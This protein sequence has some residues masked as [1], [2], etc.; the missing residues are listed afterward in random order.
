LYL[1]WF[2]FPL[3]WSLTRLGTFNPTYH[4]LNL[5]ILLCL[6]QLI[7][8]WF[9]Q[10]VQTATLHGNE[11]SVPSTR[12]TSIKNVILYKSGSYIPSRCTRSPELFLVGGRVVVGIFLS[13]I[14]R[15]IKTEFLWIVLLLTAIQSIFRT[16]FRW[17]P[18]G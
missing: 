14:S 15:I 10:I 11:K 13:V 12:G 17:T 3:N 5:M 6:H 8:N 18:R 9:G 16:W 4:L 1:L 2:T 7:T